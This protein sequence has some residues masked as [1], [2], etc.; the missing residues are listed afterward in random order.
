M[1]A[2][3]EHRGGQPGSGQPGGG[4]PGKAGSDHLVVGLTGGIGVGK[5]TAAA[6]LAAR[7]AHVVDVDL[8]CKEVIEPGGPAHEAVL[9]RFGRQLLTPQGLLDRAALG[10][11]VFADPRALSDLTDLSHPAANRVMAERVAALPEGSVVVLDMAVLVEYPRLGRWGDGPDGGY[12]QV[13]VVETPL[14]VRLDRLVSQRGM[15]RDD[16]LARISAQVTDDDRRARA[17]HVLDNG[18]DRD[19]LARQV[20]ELWARL[21]EGRRSPPER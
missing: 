14:E 21:V 20:D 18:G 7:G 13:I 19:H 4:Q 12:Q 11:I 5:S 16:A 3:N 8:V 9:D 1:A 6:L 15:S 10:A 17:D 2:A